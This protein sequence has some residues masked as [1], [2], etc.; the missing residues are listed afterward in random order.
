MCMYV[1]RIH[2]YIYTV[3]VDIYRYYIMYREYVWEKV[4]IFY[5]NKKSASKLAVKEN[6][7]GWN[8]FTRRLKVFMYLWFDASKRYSKSDLPWLPV[9][10]RR[11]SFLKEFCNSGT[12]LISGAP[13]LLD[14]RLAHPSSGAKQCPSGSPHIYNP[15]SS[16]PWG[17][18]AQNGRFLTSSPLYQVST[19]PFPTVQ[20]WQRS[21]APS[22]I[23]SAAQQQATQA[24]FVTDSR[25]Y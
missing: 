8:I 24:F 25:R 15:W 9:K 1:M 7:T 16:P 12:V 19:F 23:R 2:L 11:C 3:C 21:Q 10:S 5:H 18:G 13:H 17:F 22:I 20:C 14:G 4:H 6:L